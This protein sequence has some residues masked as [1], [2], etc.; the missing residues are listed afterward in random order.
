M[1]KHLAMHGTTG[2]EMQFYCIT[3]NRDVDFT[4]HPTTYMSTEYRHPL[5]CYCM[6]ISN[7]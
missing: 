5:D 1:P 2:V 3:L 4:F 6:R 7:Q